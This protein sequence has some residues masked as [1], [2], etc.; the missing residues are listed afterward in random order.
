[1]KRKSRKVPILAKMLFPETFEDAENALLRHMPVLRIPVMRE[2]L[3]KKASFLTMLAIGLSSEGD[4]DIKEE[5]GDEVLMCIF[6][7]KESLSS[8]ERELDEEARRYANYSFMVKMV[9]DH[10]RGLVPRT[11]QIRYSS[12]KL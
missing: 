8:S 10:V 12:K 11:R 5:R 7:P 3:Y 6:L 4:W 1:M 2:L 9:G